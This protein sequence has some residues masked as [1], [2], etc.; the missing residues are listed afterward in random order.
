METTTAN[1]F[2]TRRKFNTP[3]AESPINQDVA[4]AVSAPPEKKAPKPKKKF[5]GETGN[6]PETT[7]LNV[8]PQAEL[9]DRPDNSG[10][11]TQ[12]DPLN[13]LK[14][15]YSNEE[16]LP[17]LDSLLHHGY[18][19]HRFNMRG[20]EVMLRTRF[21]WEEQYIYQHLEDSEIKSQLTY[22]REYAF[23]TIAASLVKYGDYLFDPINKGTN[24]QLEN[25]ISDRY[26]FVRSLNSVITDILQ[27]KLND[28]DDKQRYIIDNFDN[29]LKAF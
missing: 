19:L 20:T 5:T 16:I 23:I 6:D 29:L 7:K 24:E 14:K 8:E 21:T 17:I 27:M 12:L 2:S 22:Q 10:E 28:F 15:V 13:P 26:E 25:S 1:P 4:E 11:V 9:S 3:T 18:A